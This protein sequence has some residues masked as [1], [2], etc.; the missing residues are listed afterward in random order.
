MKNCC[1]LSSKTGFACGC[2]SWWC[3]R[4]CLLKEERKKIEEHGASAPGLEE[5]RER[6]KSCKIVPLHQRRRSY[7][8]CELY[9]PQFD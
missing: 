8:C 1:F 2:C 3:K 4:C 9:Q 6:R 7:S 5:N